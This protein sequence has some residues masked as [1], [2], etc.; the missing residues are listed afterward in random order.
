MA[1]AETRTRDVGGDDVKQDMSA[2]RSDMDKL[3]RDMGRFTRQR[4]GAGVDKSARFVDQNLS[5]ATERSRNYVRDNPL[6]A[7]AAAA[8]V[9]FA[10]ALL[11]RR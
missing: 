2:L 4:V 5:E 3:I 8:V 10:V 7:C 9:G 11:L 6:A 1:T